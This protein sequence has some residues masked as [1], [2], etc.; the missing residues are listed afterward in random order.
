MIG[1][2]IGSRNRILF[3][4]TQTEVV[5]IK[6]IFAADAFDYLQDPE[7]RALDFSDVQVTETEEEEAVSSQKTKTVSPLI[8]RPTPR[9]FRQV[10]LF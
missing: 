9:N 8:S 5:T 3:C 6:L 7:N 4:F 1:I 10:S 2:W